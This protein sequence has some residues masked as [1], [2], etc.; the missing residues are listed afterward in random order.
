MGLCFGAASSHPLLAHPPPSSPPV[1][2]HILPHRPLTDRPPP[3]PAY[4][5]PACPPACPPAHQVIRQVPCQELCQVPCQARCLVRFIARR[6]ARGPGPKGC[7]RANPGYPDVGFPTSGCGGAEKLSCTPVGQNQS[8]LKQQCFVLVWGTWTGTWQGTSTLPGTWPKQ[9]LGGRIHDQLRAPEILEVAAIHFRN[10]IVIS[11]NKKVQF[12]PP[13]TQCPFL[14]SGR[15]T[16]GTFGGCGAFGTL[17]TKGTKGAFG[18]FGT[19]VPLVPL[20]CVPRVPLVPLVVPRV[21]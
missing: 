6:L 12:W 20:P 21:L 13:A 18:T 11:R 14:C 7:K 8:I 5:L 4:S 17:G 2:A 3:T 16:L 10:I 15:G 9:A 19:L 1:A